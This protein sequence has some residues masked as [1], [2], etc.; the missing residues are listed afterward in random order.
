MVKIILTIPKPAAVLVFES[1][2]LFAGV[3]LVFAGVDEAAVED[4]FSK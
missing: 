4:I 3:E 1:P 2:E